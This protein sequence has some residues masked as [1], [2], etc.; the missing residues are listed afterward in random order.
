[1]CSF[2]QPSLGTDM[3][4]YPPTSV[5]C[6]PS[7]NFEDSNTGYSSQLAGD[8]DS[9]IGH[10]EWVENDSAAVVGPHL[11][12]TTLCALSRARSR[13]RLLTDTYYSHQPAFQYSPVTHPC[14]YAPVAAAQAPEPRTTDVLCLLAGNHC[15]GHMA[16][17]PRSVKRD[18][19]HHL[20]LFHGIPLSPNSGTSV[21]DCTWLGCVCS[22]RG[23]RCDGRLP[24]SHAAHVNNLAEHIAHSHLDFRYACNLCER[25]EWSTPYALHRHRGRCRGKVVARCVG[26]LDMF[27]SQSAL[28]GHV[29]RER[30]YSTTT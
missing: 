24:R 4:G 3:F 18:I 19:A 16:L 28:E 13:I 5:V 9:H 21:R 7:F 1:M 29:E 23:S 30:C 10:A 27:E 14:L 17:S 15:S 22:L 11:M 12:P 8:A 2:P 20:S 25:A 26:C 6:K